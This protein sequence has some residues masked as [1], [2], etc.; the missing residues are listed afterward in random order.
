MA[1]KAKSARRRGNID[2]PAKTSLAPANFN[3]R[4]SLS[5]A[6]MDRRLEP[7]DL[8]DNGQLRQQ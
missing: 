1:R 5:G 4:Q 8:F 3:I 7:Q 6:E 2:N